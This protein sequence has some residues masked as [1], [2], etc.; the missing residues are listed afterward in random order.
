MELR[1]VRPVM[2]GKKYC[3]SSLEY[4]ECSNCGEELYDREAMRKIEEK[5]PTLKNLKSRRKVAA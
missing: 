3:V 5:S 1:Y 4:Y 2:Y